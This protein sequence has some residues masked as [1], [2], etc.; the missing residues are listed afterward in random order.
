[1]ANSD[2]IKAGEPDV[3]KTNS[4]GLWCWL[5]LLLIIVFAAVIRGRLATMPLERDEGEYAYIAQEMLRGI[6]P[7]ESAYS[8]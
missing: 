7:Y 6:P 2:K 4:H 3:Q 1:M 5:V 8:M